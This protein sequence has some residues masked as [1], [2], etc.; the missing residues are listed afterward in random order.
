MRK[1]LFRR[2]KDRDARQRC[3]VSDELR[4]VGYTKLVEKAIWRAERRQWMNRVML[5]QN[6]YDLDGYLVA[7][8]NVYQEILNRGDTLGRFAKNE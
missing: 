2:Y 6:A 8:I 7:S 5:T 4:Y 1:Q 3:D